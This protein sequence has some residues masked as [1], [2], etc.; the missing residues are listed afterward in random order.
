MELY[1]CFQED[2]QLEDSQVFTIADEAEAGDFGSNMINFN[3]RN[4]SL[5]SL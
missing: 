1:A 2:A 5:K 4:S 3:N